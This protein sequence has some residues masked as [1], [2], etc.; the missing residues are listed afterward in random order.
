MLIAG[1]SNGIKKQATQTI[2]QNTNDYFMDD[3]NKS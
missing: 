2:F 3:A 1:C